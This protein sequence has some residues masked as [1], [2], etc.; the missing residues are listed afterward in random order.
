M[1]RPTL[2]QACGLALLSLAASASL[3]S[4]QSRPTRSSR[5]APSK[6]APKKEEKKKDKKPDRFF[7]VHAGQVYTVSGGVLR[8]VTILSKNGK[9]VAIG[10]DL[11]LPKKTE[12][13]DAKR[14]RV[15]P[16][17]VAYNSFG[18]VGS[19]DSTDVYSLEMAIGLS[20]GITTVG[21]GNT[22]AKLTWGTLEGHIVGPRE[23][24]IRLTLRSAQQRKK[25][26]QALDQVVQYKRTVREYNLARQRGEKPTAPKPLK[27]KQ[28]LFARLL[29]GQVWAYARAD[30][31]ADLARLVELATHYGF[32]V[33]LEGGAEAWTMAPELSRAGFRV[34]VVPRSRRSESRT[35]NKAT[36]WSIENAAI[37]HKHGIPVT[38]M[39]KSAGIGLW[40]LAGSDLFT[41]PLEGAFA[42]RG[43]L[44]QAEA[45]KGLTLNPARFMGVEDRVGSIEVG[46]DC[47]LVVTRGDLLHYETLPEW[48]VVNGR[49]AYD[50][51]KDTLLRHV[52]ARDVQGK[53]LDV[54]L[55]WPRTEAPREGMKGE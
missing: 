4:A 38:I 34:I 24:T 43:G 40:G 27:G 50:K 29:S 5:P 25:L 31:R 35:S 22:V 1:S 11:E 3:A 23:T 33:M 49:I 30:A 39:S 8:D 13:L 15:Y 55:L 37:L 16:G 9:I 6:P 36:G 28:A 14:Y 2:S 47:D 12:V 18:L 10:R 7:A 54:P 42:V 53:N 44:P 51:A 32:R 48:T 26:R 46:K 45:L 41:L 19:A 21:A 20:T 17:L 52:R